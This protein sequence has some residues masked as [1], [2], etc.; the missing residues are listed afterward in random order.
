MIAS[1]PLHLSDTQLAVVRRAAALLKPNARSQ[2]LQSIARELADVDSDDD[3]AVEQ[4]VEA[5]MDAAGR[6]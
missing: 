4:A 6:R 3:E 1:R 5:I 2:F